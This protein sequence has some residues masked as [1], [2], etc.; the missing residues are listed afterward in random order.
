M[1]ANTARLLSRARPARA[2]APAL[3]LGFLGAACL[4]LDSNQTISPTSAQ[5]ALTITPPPGISAQLSISGPGNFAKTIPADGATT[6][7]LSGLVP[8]AYTFAAPSLVVPTSLVDTVWAAD[9]SMLPGGKLTLTAGQ[10]ATLAIPYAVR[11]GTGS[12]ALTHFGDARAL[13]LWPAGSLLAGTNPPATAELLTS[14]QDWGGMAVDSAGV[15]W[16]L[17]NDLG[18]STFVEFAPAAFAAGATNPMPTLLQAG[19]RLDAFCLD[20]AGGAWG[21]SKSEGKLYYW[22]AATIAG[23]NLLTADVIL[24]GAA[25][26]LSAP[27]AL[28][29]DAT[30]SLWVA[31]AAPAGSTGPAA[32]GTLARLVPRQL[33]TSGYALP[34]IQLPVA[35]PTALAFDA[36][37]NLWVVSAANTLLEF[38]AAQLDGT[39]AA[40][41][42]TLAL[43]PDAAASALAF[44]ALGDLLVALLHATD[45]SGALVLFTPGQLA[46]G[47]TQAGLVALKTAPQM[48]SMS[49]L[50]V[51]PTPA[52]LPLAG[53]PK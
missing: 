14:Y 49:L 51:D 39:S 13:S 38:A 11:P 32:L 44:D 22:S 37:G 40:P 45:N 34:G 17:A 26:S 23:G 21:A 28:A 27:V 47:G 53:A 46:L 20:G 48:G 30:G 4:D 18:T 52:G 10:S 36:M 33:A 19:G 8:G 29:L 15:V 50:L 42:V 25:G 35:A 2:L 3:L 41:A 7:T 6:V 12:I 1:L 43:D 16:M 24:Q 5:L 31:N 9:L